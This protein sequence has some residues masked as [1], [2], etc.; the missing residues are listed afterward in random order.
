MRYSHTA[1]SSP[2]TNV[3]VDILDTTTAV[4]S[5]LPP[6][7]ANHNGVIRFYIIILTERL[8]NSQVQLTAEA[9]S[10]VL[11]SLHPSYTYEVSVGAVT[12]LVGPYSPVSVFHLPE[13]GKTCVLLHSIWL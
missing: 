10:E 5:W 4:I 12:T 3:T 7:P 8:T 13:D 11:L 1:P 2:P 6:P 9:T